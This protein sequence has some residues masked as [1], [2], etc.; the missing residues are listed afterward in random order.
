MKNII[1]LTLEN[2]V[3]AAIIDPH[4]M[5]TAVNQFLINAGKTPLFKV[6]LLGLSKK[7][8]L[9][10]GLV[11]IHPTRFLKEPPEADLVIIPAI[12]GDIN[13]ALKANERFLPW[14]VAQYQ[15]GAE[16]AS[17]C[18]GA[19]M[20]ASTGLLNGKTCSTHWLFANEFRERFPQVH[21]ADDKVITADRGL[22]SSGG[23]QSYWNLL[24]YLIEKYASREMAIMASKFFAIEIDR[25]AQS[26]FIIFQGQ[27]KHNDEAIKNAQ[28]Y[29][30]KHFQ[31]KVSVDEL[32]DRFGIGRRTFER[33]F[34]KAT[35]NTV[36]EYIQR[37][38]IEAAK[39]QLE[40]GVKN[41][42]EVMFEVGY[43]DSR[44]FRNLFK[45]ITG[46]SP[47]AYRNKY[48]SIKIP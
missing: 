11:S 31:E 36:A 3:P 38:K 24:L 44:T 12:T 33:R 43:T 18:I 32:S 15:K 22:Y 9:S 28:E 6:E 17:L 46:L 2:S 29:V 39:K 19:F 27:R 16:I 26:V 21:L 42:N 35:S 34:K 10:E 20:L 37:V 7:V 8:K 5:F 4:Y 40:N 48:S 47:L 13:D 1:I 25:N 30:E 23:A 45:K 41:V 14:I